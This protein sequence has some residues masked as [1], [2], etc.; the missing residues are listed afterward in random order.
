MKKISQLKKELKSLGSPEKAKNSA[1]FFKTG[2]GQYGEGDVFIGI[3]VPEQ[4]RVSKKYLDLDL[5][6]IQT[7][8]EDKFH[9]CR[10]VG[11]LILVAQFEKAEEKNRKKIYNFYLK[12]YKQV[13]NWDLVD[14]SAPNIVGTYLF[15][16]PRDVLYK[17][18]RSNHLWKK[19]I[20]IVA[21]WKLIRLGE[22]NDTFDIVKILMSDTHDLIHKACGWMLREAGKKDEDKLKKFLDKYTGQMPRTMLRYSIERLS[23]KDRKYYL[24][25]K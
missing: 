10:L 22:L 23:E 6:D 25:K 3:T 8:L 24:H 17:M 18:A 16:K 9:E 21:N 19:R 5:V 7:L 1:W 20:S 2:P 15:D 11:L 4:R 12:N 13:N 14:L